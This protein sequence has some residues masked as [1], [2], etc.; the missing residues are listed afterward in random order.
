MAETIRKDSLFRFSHL[1]DLLYQAPTHQQG[2]Q[3]FLELLT[4]EFKLCDAVLHI[5]NTISNV[6]EGAW[7]AG[8]KAD[9]LIQFVES[10]L[11]KGDVLYKYIDHAPPSKFYTLLSD[12]GRPESS[13]LTPIQLAVE[14]WFDG[15]EFLDA[16][17]AIVGRLENQVAMITVHRD[18]SNPAFSSDD[19]LVFN[20][21]IPHIQRAFTLY[22]QF[23]NIRNETS[24]LHHLIAQLPH[25]ALLYDSKG[26]LIC[27]N[28]KAIELGELYSDL[29]VNA[30]RF[31]INDVS[32]KREYI[33]NLFNVLKQGDDIKQACRVTHL[34]NKQSP[35]TI[36][37]VPIGINHSLAND[38]YQLL[39]GYEIGAIVYLY[40]RQHPIHVNPE[41]LKA[42]FGLTDTET[43]ICELIVSGYNRNEIATILERSAYTVKDHIKSVFLKTGSHSQS[44][45]IATLL[46]S[47]IYRTA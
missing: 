46:T 12:I 45:L 7:I 1:I 18:T 40:D 35:I 31:S 16:S 3:P 28:Q 43:T 42:I 14:Q 4:I 8:P 39:K 19:V 5:Q 27:V 29:E 33:S 25:G 11:E 17:S 10:K 36:L 6:T 24:N 20:E 37:L 13:T 21:L 47:P 34:T 32:V 23:K 41:F 15:N 9:A 30:N 2:F 22:Q 44:D 26:E 38:E